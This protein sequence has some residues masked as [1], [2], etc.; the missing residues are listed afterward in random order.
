MREGSFPEDR[1]P[2]PKH[3]EWKRMFQAEI[4]LREPDSAVNGFL[5]K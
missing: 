3:G 2:V 1:G 5:R 4:N